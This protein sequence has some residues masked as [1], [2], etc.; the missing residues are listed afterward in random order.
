M[1]LIPFI[2]EKLGVKIGEKFKIGDEAEN[3]YPELEK[4]IKEGVDY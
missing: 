1:N 4:Y 2:A 3:G